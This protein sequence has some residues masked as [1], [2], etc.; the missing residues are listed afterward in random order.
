MVPPRV[1]IPESIWLSNLTER[2]ASPLDGKNESSGLGAGT[3]D[4]VLRVA[5]LDP[6][7]F[8]LVLVVDLDASITSMHNIEI[9]VDHP[10]RL[11]V[12]HRRGD[13]IDIGSD[14]PPSIVPDPRPPLPGRYDLDEPMAGGDGLL[15]PATKFGAG[16]SP[17]PD[18]VFILTQTLH[19]EGPVGAAIPLRESNANRLATHGGEA[20]GPRSANSPPRAP[21]TCHR[22][23]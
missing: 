21:T 14:R 12:P 4:D 15:S 23:E 17:K 19:V 20:T 1:R 3:V 22:N 7:I 13:H 5:E 9:E 11:T 16:G 8:E 10:N 2:F 18:A 6:V